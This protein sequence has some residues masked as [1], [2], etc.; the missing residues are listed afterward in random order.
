M[1]KFVI[2]TKKQK[3]T[4]E[5]PTSSREDSENEKLNSE[6]RENSYV[7]SGSTID[8]TSGKRK[9]HSNVYNYFKR[10]ADRKLALTCG[11]EYKTSGNT[12]NLADHIKRFHRFM[13]TGPDCSVSTSTT[14]LSTSSARSSAQSI[15]QFFKRS[16][17]YDSSSQT[18]KDS[19]DCY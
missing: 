14:E 5:K 3:V 2:T 13:S 10:S 15:S 12:S 4:E 7:D 19:D 17:Q 9:R 1:E 6:N 18:K 16:V 11:R 8:L